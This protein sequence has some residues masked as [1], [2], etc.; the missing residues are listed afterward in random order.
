[1]S[2]FLENF[3][4]RPVNLI[5]S[6]TNDPEPLMHPFMSTKAAQRRRT[7]VLSGPLC[8]L[9]LGVD[10]GSLTTLRQVVATA[11]GQALQF[12]RVK[13]C[14]GSNLMRVVVCLDT[15]AKTMVLEAI[16]RFLPGTE[17]YR[18]AETTLLAPAGG[19]P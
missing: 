5:S 1:M 4:A 19:T 12:V 7:P 17:F 10:V 2:H 11:G 3:Y 16:E 9:H 8:M 13:T 6:V 14:P 18:Q 15:A